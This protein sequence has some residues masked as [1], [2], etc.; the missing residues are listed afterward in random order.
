MRLTALL[1]R[2]TT[3][4]L[5]GLNKMTPRSEVLERGVFSHATEID[6]TG[7]TLEP[8]QHTK[9][10]PQPIQTRQN[11]Q[12]INPWHITPPKI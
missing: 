6:A 3:E 7:N 1:L 5:R 4:N 9:L 10:S 11:Q 2:S 12:R 8:T